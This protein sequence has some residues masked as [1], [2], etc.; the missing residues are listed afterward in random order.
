M[1]HLL[2]RKLTQEYRPFLLTHQTKTAH[3]SVNRDFFWGN[4]GFIKMK[5]P[6]VYFEFS[7]YSTSYIFYES[8][9]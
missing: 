2:F 7:D 9:R 6:E 8:P 3:F 5:S 1:T 4:A